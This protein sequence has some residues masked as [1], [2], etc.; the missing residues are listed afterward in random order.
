MVDNVRRLREFIFRIEALTLPTVA[1]AENMDIP[2]RLPPPPPTR[3]L[4]LAPQRNPFAS[5]CGPA[6]SLN[7]QCTDSSGTPT[8]A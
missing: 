4:A 3:K 2:T 8:R 7:P 5:A 1:Q 6:K